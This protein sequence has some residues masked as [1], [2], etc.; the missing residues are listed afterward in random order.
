ML[1]R[2]G[3]SGR[4][5]LHPDP[6]T[7]VEAVTDD[8]GSVVARFSYAP[9]GRR[10]VIDGDPDAAGPLGFCGTLG[11]REEAGGLLDMRAR[12]YDPD[13]GRFTSPDPWPA[14]LPEPL[15]LNR[16]LYALGDP[17]SQVDPYGLFCLTGKNDKGKCR[18]LKDVVTGA[19]DVLEEP[20][21]TVST[22]ATGVAAVAA[23]VSLYCPPCIVVSGPVA[24]F[25][26]Q[27]AFFTGI[28]AA[29][30]TCAA[31]WSFSF[32][33]GVKVVSSS[34]GYAFKFV[35]KVGAE[36]LGLPGADVFAR[37]IFGLFRSGATA[38]A[39]RMQK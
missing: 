22:V 30:S 20:L 17:I 38:A 2:H 12:F 6:T 11:V 4:R 26:G 5:Y 10:A 32:D 3:P 27:T 31:D 39:R 34:A 14:H 35:S 18:G 25:A 9:F 19:G 28:A 24:G 29:A 36:V 15:T 7:S 16:Y 13:L 21:G 8:S 37:G 33:C 23:G 1:A